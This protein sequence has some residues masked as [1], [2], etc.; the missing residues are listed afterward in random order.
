MLEEEMNEPS[1]HDDESI[2]FDGS[3]DGNDNTMEYDP[4]LLVGYRY[5][6]E[7]LDVM[8]TRQEIYG[9]ITEI[10]DYSNV[11]DGH[12]RGQ[13]LYLVVY[14]HH[15]ENIDDDCSS[16]NNNNNINNSSSSIRPLSSELLPEDMA[17]GGCINYYQNHHSIGSGKS[18]ARSF[19]TS[20][21]K[22]DDDND[23]ND[24]RKKEK[25]LQL[26]FKNNKVQK[27]IHYVQWKIPTNRRK[28]M[29]DIDIG[30]RIVTNSQRPP[31]TTS[32]S[33]TTTKQQ[34][35]K[36]RL[37][38]VTMEYNNFE[39]IFQVK[40]SSVPSPTAG[41]GVFL[42]C[43]SLSITTSTPNSNRYLELVPGELLDIG[44]Y[45]PIIP[46]DKCDMCIFQCKSFILDYK[47]N[48]YVRWQE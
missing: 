13:Y 31:S 48:E 4:S 42:T 39:L 32:S 20:T 22:I 23:D 34:Q 45:A 28:E 44:I 40:Q 30:D 36:Q 27:P 19:S 35:Q 5:Y 7:W 37:P 18:N 6:Q 21:M 9:T 3:D 12:N 8:D 41:L 14:D 29:V 17:W 15:D 2:E 38:R 16:N 47:C 33:T 25:L 10:R 43:R 11:N 46:S 24:N 1:I 26:T